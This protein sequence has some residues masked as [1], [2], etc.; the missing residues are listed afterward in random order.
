M[1]KR[2][3]V[4]AAEQQKEYMSFE[5]KDFKA[6]ESI[7]GVFSVS[8]Y[9]SVYEVVDRGGDIVK[10]GCFD[11]SLSIKKPLF[12]WSHDASEPI[13]RFSEVKSD[14][15][16][17]FL[18]GEMPK[19]DDFVKGR[20]MPQVKIGSVKGFSVGFFVQEYYFDDDGNRVITKGE[21]VEVSLVTFPMNES[22]QVTSF[23]NQSTESE[24]EISEEMAHQRYEINKILG[25]LKATK[26][27]M[28]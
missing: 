28:E 17:L 14:E 21:L 26:I 8:G 13:G 16:G 6:D 4:K 10:K 1:K 9:G 27:L 15:Y 23:K 22:A 11:E 19:S 2:I 5:V 20:V 24:D 7:D 25:N 18:K 12:L 3:Q